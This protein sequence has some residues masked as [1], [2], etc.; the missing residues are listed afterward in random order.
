MV[1]SQYPYEAEVNK[2]CRRME[3]GFQEMLP[4]DQVISIAQA[5]ALALSANRLKLYLLP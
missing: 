5:L 4:T 2:T 3:R 1:M